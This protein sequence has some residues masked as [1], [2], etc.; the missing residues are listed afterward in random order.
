MICSTLHLSGTIL[1]FLM[2][3][4]LLS[5]TDRHYRTPCTDMIGV[6]FPCN[7]QSTCL[8]KGDMHHKSIQ[9][10]CSSTPGCIGYVVNDDKTV[11]T[12]KKRHVFLSGICQTLVD[13]TRYTHLCS[14]EIASQWAQHGCTQ[15]THNLS[16]PRCHWKKRHPPPTLSDK[17]LGS[18][19]P[20]VLSVNTL[21]AALI[22]K[23]FNYQSKRGLDVPFE[24]KT[25]GDRKWNKINGWHFLD[26]I[27]ILREWL[28]G[29]REID[30]DRPIVVVDGKDVIWGG[31]ARLP[32]EQWRS[33]QIV[34]SAELGCG[35]CNVP[36][37]PGC[38]GT[39]NTVPPPRWVYAHPMLKHAQCDTPQINSVGCSSPPANGYLNS[40]AFVGSK[41]SILWMLRQIQQQHDSCFFNR[42]GFAWDQTVYSRFWM[43]HQ[44]NVQLDYNASLFLS[45]Y[46]F[47]NQM[48][49]DWKRAKS[50]AG[51]YR[52]PWNSEAACFVHA[53]GVAG[54]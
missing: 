18:M 31:C 1:D 37:P 53:N 39:Y 42:A 44:D 4:L 22:E 12:L 47:K 6:D 8:Y 29:A 25:I 38:A 41:R 34:F 40:G 3:H 52:L 9:I 21:G 5:T 17:L 43:E 48:I 15:I 46:A 7:G 23:Q 16:G 32:L 24:V 26:K 27:K 45:L 11:A 14:S 10:K 19:K 49:W 36:F 28:N 13:A 2:R 35:E 20:L 50:R 33:S 54:K 51:G 30:A